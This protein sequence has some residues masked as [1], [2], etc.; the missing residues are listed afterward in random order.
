MWREW[1]PAKTEPMYNE[2]TKVCIGAETGASWVHCSPDR[3]IEWNEK[4]TN[5]KKFSYKKMLA[6]GMCLRWGAWRT[7][8]TVKGIFFWY[9]RQMGRKHRSISKVTLHPVSCKLVWTVS[10]YM[11]EVHKCNW[12]MDLDFSEHNCSRRRHWL[13]LLK[14]LFSIQIFSKLEMIYLRI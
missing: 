4:A 6:S 9:I 14:P 2:S 7:T 13:L 3:W 10:E 11:K 1:R 8:E 12:N 5:R